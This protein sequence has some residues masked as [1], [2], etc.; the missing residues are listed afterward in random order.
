MKPL[1]PKA[2]TKNVLESEVVFDEK[3][4]YGLQY[5]F[6]SGGNVA[7]ARIPVDDKVKKMMMDMAVKR[8]VE[9]AVNEMS[10][11]LA[12]EFR[13]SAIR[14]VNQAVREHLKANKKRLVAEMVEK[15]IKEAEAKLEELDDYYD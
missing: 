9:V 13:K 1:D 6:K 3:G 12:K 5:S 10:K 7:M 15:T 8:A 4:L 2:K 14:E 11:D